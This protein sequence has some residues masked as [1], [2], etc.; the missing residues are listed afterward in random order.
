MISVATIEW[1]QDEHLSIL[2]VLVNLH[3]QNVP[4]LML[5]VLFVKVT[6]PA[7]SFTSNIKDKNSSKEEFFLQDYLEYSYSYVY[8][9][10]I[11]FYYALFT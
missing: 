5:W 8:L 1:E 3:L 11:R 6:V 10:D 4:Q 2:L 7:I 9:F